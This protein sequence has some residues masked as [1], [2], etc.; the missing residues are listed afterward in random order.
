MNFEVGNVILTPHN[1]VVVITSFKT[2][3][4]NFGKETYDY[5]NYDYY[6]ERNMSGGCRLVGYT[7]TKMCSCWY[8][9]FFRCYGSEYPDPECEDCKGE[10]KVPDYR[11]GLNDCKLLAVNVTEYKKKNLKREIAKL[12]RELKNID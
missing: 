3:T 4:I 7:D 11:Y 12:K 6:G 10:G 1:S 8:D 9:P 2:H 5:V